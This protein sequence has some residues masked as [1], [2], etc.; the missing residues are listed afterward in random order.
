MSALLTTT[1]PYM[2]VVID[3]LIEN[4]V[5]NANAIGADAYCRDA[6][7]AVDTA[8]PSWSSARARPLPKW[9]PAADIRHDGEAAITGIGERDAGAAHHSDPPIVPC[10]RSAPPR[11]TLP[12]NLTHTGDER[13]I[14][15]RS[16]GHGEGGP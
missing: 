8:K 5:R 2:K 4:G 9:P 1:M 13:K 15:R 6:S 10:S 7:W 12:L 3:A 11:R 14:V 16:S